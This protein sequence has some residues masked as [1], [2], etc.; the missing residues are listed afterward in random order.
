MKTTLALLLLFGWVFSAGAQVDTNKPARF[1]TKVVCSEGTNG[2][3]GS[4]ISINPSPEA[5]LPNA[6]N[7][8]AVTSPGKECELKYK[9]MG[10]S[11][12]KDVYHFTFTRMTKAGAREKTTDT[13]DI[14]F[15]GHQT[16]VFEDDLHRVIIDSPDE[17]DLK[18]P[19]RKQV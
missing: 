11:G 13:K 17:K 15:D 12:D 19:K 6:E 7:T 4:S 14:L 18:T 8:H 10:R 1:K 9:Y 3:G 2:S 16:K 5:T